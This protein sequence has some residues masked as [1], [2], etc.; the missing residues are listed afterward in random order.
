MRKLLTIAT[1]LTVA[2]LS[3]GGFIHDGHDPPDEASPELEPYSFV[4]DQSEIDALA[5]RLDVPHD[6]AKEILLAS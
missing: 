4:E 5:S 6:L 2:T 3:S 1:T